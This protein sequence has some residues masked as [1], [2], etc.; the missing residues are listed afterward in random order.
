LT[1][2][3][4]AP[5]ANAQRLLAAGIPLEA[6]SL[7]CPVETRIS[8]NKNGNRFA[9]DATGCAAWIIPVAVPDP[10]REDVIEAID[11][12]A[13]V[14]S[15]V[16]VDLL[17]FS[18]AHQRHAL[19]LGQAVVLGAIEPEYCEPDRVPVHRTAIGWLRAACV[20]IVLL[21]KD[22]FEAGRILRQID[23]PLAED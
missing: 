3:R 22:Q 6:I 10:W 14:A 7:V 21:T 19:R 5:F 1:P 11:P 16:I 20:G 15:G 4:N 18:F 8:L 2:M 17:A 12:K 23:R 13:V 9:P